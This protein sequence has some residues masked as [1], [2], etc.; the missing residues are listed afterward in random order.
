MVYR[1]QSSNSNQIKWKEIVPWILVALLSVLLILSLVIHVMQAV[2]T[3]RRG[4]T[5]RNLNTSPDCTFATVTASNP[6]YEA[7]NVKLS[8]VQGAMHIYE[9]LISE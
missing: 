8:E 6:C 2:W 3:T 9:T 1:T 5:D 4:R 7:S